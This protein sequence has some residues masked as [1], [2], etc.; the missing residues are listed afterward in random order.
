MTMETM[1][2]HQ[3][4]RLSPEEF[5]KCGNIWDMERH[6]AQAEEWRR[7]LIAGDRITFVYLLEGQFIGEISLVHTHPDPDY[8]IPGRRAYISRLVVKPEFRRRGIGKTLV[9]F[10]SEKAAE[11]GYTELSIGVDLDNCPAI[12][13]YAEEGFDRILRVDRDEQGTY[14]KLLKIR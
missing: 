9:R 1:K 12:R 5:G 2:E 10:I 4:I 13:L 8:T 6:K 3:I 14:M 7:Q 11:L